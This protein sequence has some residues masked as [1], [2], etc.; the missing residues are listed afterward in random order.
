MGPKNT[1]NELQKSFNFFILFFN[2]ISYFIQQHCVLTAFQ[3]L[4]NSFCVH[5]NKRDAEAYVHPH[6]ASKWDD[7]N[8]TSIR[9]GR[10]RWGP[11]PET[12]N[13]L[14]PKSFHLLCRMSPAHRQE[15]EINKNTDCLLPFEFGNSTWNYGDIQ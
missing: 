9:K 14:L 5:R 10:Q 4:W 6:R 13:N 15:T 2:G 8:R 1:W 7:G 3:Q 11:C 12:Q